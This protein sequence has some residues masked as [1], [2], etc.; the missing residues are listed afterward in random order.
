MSM[1]FPK[2]LM[3]QEQQQQVPQQPLDRHAVAV[4][5]ARRYTVQN[6]NDLM[7]V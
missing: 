6:E 1:I 7:Q 5:L 2:H 4:N 3:F